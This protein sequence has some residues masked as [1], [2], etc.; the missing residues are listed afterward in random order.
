MGNAIGQEH[1]GRSGLRR[2]G[3]PWA[4]IVP[5][6]WAPSGGKAVPGPGSTAWSAAAPG[7]EEGPRLNQ[8][9]P[10]YLRSVL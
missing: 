10:S 9:L 1:L 8:L 4:G 7:E 6:G 5:A 3:T 2:G